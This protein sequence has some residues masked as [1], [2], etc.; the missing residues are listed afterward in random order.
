MQED[1][2]AAFTYDLTGNLRWRTGNRRGRIAGYITT[3][4]HR[5]GYKNRSIKFHG[6]CQSIGRLI[7]IY[8]NGDI[9]ADQLIDHINGDACDNKLDNLRLVSHAANMFNRKTQVNS[10]TGIPGLSYIKKTGRWKVQ[11]GKSASHFY[12][13]RF[14]SKQEA[15]SALTAKRA[16]YASVLG[17]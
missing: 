6:R 4:K 9:T 2:L 15:I 12:Q 11:V 10:T 1:L 17:I 5:G 3:Q 7:Y 14:S 16:E 8:F 13:K